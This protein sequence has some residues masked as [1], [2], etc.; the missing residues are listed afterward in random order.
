LD[1]Y[2]IGAGISEVIHLYTTKNIIVGCCCTHG[3]TLE[4][5]NP[6]AV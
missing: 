2:T 6:T 5:K 1:R 4:K 3:N